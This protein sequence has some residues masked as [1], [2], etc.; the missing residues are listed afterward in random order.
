MG[1]RGTRDYVEGGWARSATDVLQLHISNVG[2][3]TH[4]SQGYHLV[5]P[6]VAA[7]CSSCKICG[8]RLVRSAVCAD[9]GIE[10]VSCCVYCCAGFVPCVVCRVV[11]CCVAL[12][13]AVVMLCCCAVVLLCSCALVLLCFC[14]VLCCV[15]LCFVL[16]CVVLCFVL[17]CV[18]LCFVVSCNVMCCVSCVLIFCAVYSFVSRRVVSCL[19]SCRGVVFCVVVSC[20]QSPVASCRTKRCD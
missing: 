12:C 17:C 9:R 5:T 13:C 8:A 6:P 20:C 15:V 2:V 1:L 16:C 14:A 4:V 11:S 3:Q 19:A 10:K 18:V 7:R